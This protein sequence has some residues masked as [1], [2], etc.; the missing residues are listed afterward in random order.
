MA[1]HVVYRNQWNAQCH[2]RSL[3]KIDAHEQRADQPRRAGDS[4]RINVRARNSCR[5]QR[6]V[7]QLRDHLHVGARRNLRHDASIHRVQIRL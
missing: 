1:A 4:N 3:R 2:G 6:P 7:G 5:L